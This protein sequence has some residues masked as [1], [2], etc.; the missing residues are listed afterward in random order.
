MIH[1]NSDGE[2]TDAS[3]I[4]WLKLS[5]PS[6]EIKLFT[7]KKMRTHWPAIR[8]QLTAKN[9]TSKSPVGVISVVTLKR[10]ETTFD[11]SQG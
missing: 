7:N 2:K 11:H 9:V 3:S 8:M 6:S 10:T 1:V 5:F 4:A